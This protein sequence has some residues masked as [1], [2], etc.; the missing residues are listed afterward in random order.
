MFYNPDVYNILP[1]KNT[2]NQKEE[3]VYTAFFIPAYNM[4]IQYCDERG[5][6]DSVKAKEFYENERRK[7]AAIPSELVK[8]KSEFCFYPEEALI[9]EG[10]NRFDSE[11]LAEQITNVDILKLYDAPIRG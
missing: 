1:Y 10:D 3:V 6:C 5:V 11:K 9:R 2:Y 8:Y 7:K 4:C